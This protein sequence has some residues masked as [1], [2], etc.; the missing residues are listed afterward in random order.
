MFPTR[1]L[2]R[3]YG[4]SS[5][6]PAKSIGYDEV[7]KGEA[8]APDEPVMGANWLPGLRPVECDLDTYFKEVFAGKVL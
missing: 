2:A 1:I 7:F 5:Q 3:I 4:L 6:K 8:S